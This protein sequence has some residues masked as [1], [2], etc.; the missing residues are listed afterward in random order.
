MT[1]RRERLERRQDG[2]SAP[3]DGDVTASPR[4]DPG[5]AQPNTQAPRHGPAPPAPHHVP[6]QRAGWVFGYPVARPDFEP[7]PPWARPA[8]GAAPP[9]SRQPF[10]IGPTGPADP[11]REESGRPPRRAVLVALGVAIPVLAGAVGASAGVLATLKFGPALISTSAP[12]PSD[13]LGSTG[14][15]FPKPESVATVAQA[16]L[17]SVVQI[18]VAGGQGNATGSGFVIRKDGYILTNNHVIEPAAGGGGIKVAFQSGEEVS[19]TVVGRSPSYDL[20]VIRVKRRQAL[21][22]LALGN[23]DD[24]RGRA[25]RWWRSARRSGSP[26]P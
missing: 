16:L 19:A 24:V 1:E 26:A 8:A 21:R 10:G 17:P 6:A 12:P 11:G 2:A 25:D 4:T 18:K 22:P 14:S 5:A 23:S 9:P 13:D 15:A 3:P 20:A 7:P